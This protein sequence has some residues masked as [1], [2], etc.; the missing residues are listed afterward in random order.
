[1]VW[2]K[3]RTTDMSVPNLLLLTLRCNELEMRSTIIAQLVF[4]EQV[5]LPEALTRVKIGTYAA[6]L[7]SNNNCT[8]FVQNLL[9]RLKETESRFHPWP[10]VIKLFLSVTYEFS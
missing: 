3:L 7:V 1:M 4:C 5:L 9:N 10:N 6:G 8:N 2:R